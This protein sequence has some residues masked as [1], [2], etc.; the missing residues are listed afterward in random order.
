MEPDSLNWATLHINRAEGVRDDGK[1]P[2]NPFVGRYGRQITVWPV[3]LVFAPV[4][5][6]EVLSLVEAMQISKSQADAMIDLPEAVVG[7]YPWDQVVWQRR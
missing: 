2:D 3:K 1:R 6:D 4:V 5:A 7:R